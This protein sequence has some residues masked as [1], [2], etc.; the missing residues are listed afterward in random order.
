MMEMRFEEATAPN[1]PKCKIRGRTHS[2]LFL[3][4]NRLKVCPASGKIQKLRA[5]QSW[6]SSDRAFV[7]TI[8]TLDSPVWRGN[9]SSHQVFDRKKVEMKVSPP[10]KR[11]GCVC[12]PY[13]VGCRPDR[14]QTKVPNAPFELDDHLVIDHSW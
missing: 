1:D 8:P 12:W 2:L 11:L 13:G 7:G 4:S 5:S 9:D 6:G 14:E 3:T 10:K